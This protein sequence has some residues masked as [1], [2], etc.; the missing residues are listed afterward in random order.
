MHKKGAWT[1]PLRRGQPDDPDFPAL[2]T[3]AI[4]WDMADQDD[5]DVPIP[6]SNH[7]N[8]VLNSEETDGMYR[9]AAKGSRTWGN[10]QFFQILTWTHPATIGIQ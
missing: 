5:I 4:S 8:A 9:L 10:R 1:G 7:P 3:P 6:N 2:G